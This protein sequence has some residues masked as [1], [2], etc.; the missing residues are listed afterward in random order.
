MLRFAL[1][2]FYRLT[3]YIHVPLPPEDPKLV[4]RRCARRLRAGLPR[5]LVLERRPDQVALPVRKVELEKETL[6]KN[7]ALA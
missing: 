6:I 7:S 5:H 4:E 3:T 1:T 2:D